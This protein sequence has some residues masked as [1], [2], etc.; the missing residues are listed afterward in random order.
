MEWEGGVLPDVGE[1]GGHHSGLGLADGGV[2]ALGFAVA[3][4]YGGRGADCTVGIH[5]FGLLSFSIWVSV[6]DVE[7]Q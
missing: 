2:E 3:L 1:E 5:G 7:G 6:S 4:D